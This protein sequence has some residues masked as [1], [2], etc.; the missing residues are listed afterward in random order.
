M[1]RVIFLFIILSTVSILYGQNN[2]D[3]KK[4]YY[5]RIGMMTDSIL[6]NNKLFLDTLYLDF[7]SEYKSLANDYDV[8]YKD[9]VYVIIKDSINILRLDLLNKMYSLLQSRI[10]ALYISFKDSLKLFFKEYESIIRKSQMEYA[11]CND[12]TEVEDYYD[13]LDEYNDVLDSVSSD[14]QD[15]ASILMDSLE[16]ALSDSAGIYMDSISNYAETLLENQLDE[17]ELTG[18]SSEVNSPGKVYDEKYSKLTLE[19]NY[20]NHIAYRGRDNH[21]YQN[22]FS[23][24]LTFEHPSGF[25]IS[26]VFYFAN[27]NKKPLDELD[28]M[29]Y[30]SF[31]F[32]DN[33]NGTF[34][35]THYFFSDNSLNPR[36]ILTNSIAGEV[37]F[38]Y[39]YFNF[40]PTLNLDFSGSNSE[41]S[42]FLYASSPIELTKNFL[43]GTLGIEPS[44][45]ATFG[46]QTSAFLTKIRNRKG[47]LVNAPGQKNIFS[48]MDYEFSF[49]L[50]YT[51]KYLIVKPY[52]TVIVPLNVLDNS[53]KNPFLNF[54]IEI[55][56]PFDFK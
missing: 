31:D 30:F 17:Y 27:K 10:R 42:L 55:G 6:N 36:A 22:S 2:S 9:S 19:A 7:D 51:S 48:I 35:F 41:F 38:E 1:K 44:V 24:A 54:T 23:P 16:S 12:C 37:N 20:Y 4:Y 43:D 39:P 52:A 45:T 28:L 49:P 26:T 15:N 50:V 13:R 56:I 46:E 25:G 21:I 33:I 47:K 32:S 40:T 29:G 18:I 8:Y 11:A 34:Y 3:M 14:F 53:E 5:D